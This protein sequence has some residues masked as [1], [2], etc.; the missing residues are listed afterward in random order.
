METEFQNIIEE[1]LILNRRGYIPSVSRNLYNAAGLT[2]ENY[3]GKKPDSMFFPDYEGIEIKT[4]RRYSGYDI[5]LFSLAFDGPNLFESNYLLETYGE[6]DKEFP[7]YRKLIVF[8]RINQK[9]LVS[10]RYYFELLIDHDQKR[11]LI[12]IYDIDM[13]FIEDR[14]FIYFDSIEQRMRVKLSK[15]AL[16]YVSRKKMEDDLFFRYY[17]L[18]CYRY[19][20]MDAFIH[21]LTHGY[22]KATLIL[23]FSKSSKNFGKNTS[24]SMKFQIKKSKVGELF[25]RVYLY[26]H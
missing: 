4:T 21:C 24:Q 11:I 6:R 20:G 18:E 25:E 23:T 12:R 10:G 7:E 26:E 8:L 13:N 2:L 19:K 5:S 9:V 1:F 14:A 17:K 3:L 16:F 22:V 15:L